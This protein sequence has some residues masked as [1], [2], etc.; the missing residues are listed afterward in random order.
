LVLENKFQPALEKEFTLLLGNYASTTRP[1]KQSLTTLLTAL[2]QFLRKTKSSD[3]IQNIF[4][5]ESVCTAALALVHLD[6]LLARGQ[7][8]FQQFSLSIAVGGSNS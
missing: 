1:S 2:S 4:P 6:K 7:Y 8:L 5:K 3:T